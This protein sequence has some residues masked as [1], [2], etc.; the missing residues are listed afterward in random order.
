M[1]TNEEIDPAAA[2]V[3]GCS[4]RYASGPASSE[5]TQNKNRTVHARVGDIFARDAATGWYPETHQ[6]F[7]RAGNPVAFTLYGRKLLT[8]ILQDTRPTKWFHF[9]QFWTRGRRFPKPST[10]PPI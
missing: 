5:T 6:H 4:S 3:S 10:S 2:G 1:G 8:A 7:T 9:T